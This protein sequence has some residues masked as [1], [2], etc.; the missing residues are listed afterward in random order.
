MISFRILHETA[1]LSTIH[2]EVDEIVS[3]RKVCL[4]GV[5]D[6]MTERRQVVVILSLR[7]AVQIFPER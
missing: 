3:V 6:L 4:G 7:N 2:L 5:I 1:L